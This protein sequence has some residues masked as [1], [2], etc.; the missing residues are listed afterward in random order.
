M[1]FV[2]HILPGFL[3][4]I[5]I[6]S[7]FYACC[8]FVT[9][10]LFSTGIQQFVLIVYY[11]WTIN[12]TVKTINEEYVNQYGSTNAVIGCIFF[13]LPLTSTIYH[14]LYM[15]LL[16]L[17]I[18]TKPFSYHRQRKRSVYAALVLIWIFVIVLACS[19]G[20]DCSIC[21]LNYALFSSNLRVLE[22]FLMR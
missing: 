8:F 13:L 15:S 22:K 17:Y 10:Y 1:H 5:N 19:P 9:A 4:R 6:S 12:S 21:L 3:L 7:K 11:S 14:L 18:I 20:T 2:H 16:R